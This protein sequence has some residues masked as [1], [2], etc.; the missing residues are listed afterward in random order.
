MA[1]HTTLL[2]RRAVEDGCNRGT[3][4]IIAEQV[5]SDQAAVRAWKDDR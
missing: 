1:E 2:G 3:M 5:A 4:A